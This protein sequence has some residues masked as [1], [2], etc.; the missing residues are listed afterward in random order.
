MDFSVLPLP[1]IAA[2]YA[3]SLPLYLTWLLGIVLALRALRD[4]PHVARYT[5]LAL[6]I[7]MGLSLLSIPITATLPLVLRRAPVAT[8]G[9]YF[10]V[11]GV[12][13]Q[14]CAAVAWILLLVALFGSR[15]EYEYAPPATSEHA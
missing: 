6:L 2:Q 7:L 8:L 15:S 5:L 12:V 4:R 3:A 13:N 14:L 11:I 1:T 10:F 9:L